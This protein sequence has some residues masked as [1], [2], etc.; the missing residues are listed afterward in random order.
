MEDLINKYIIKESDYESD[1]S[2]EYNLINNIYNKCQPFLKEWI[3]SFKNKKLKIWYSGRI[4][5]GNVFTGKIRTDRKPMNTS[6]KYH[7]PLNKYFKDT[8][9]IEYR[10]N[11]IF[12][13]GDY[14]D[15][16]DYGQGSPFLIFPI[17]NY[18]YL[19]SP[20]IDDLYMHTGVIFSKPLDS[21]KSLLSSYIHNKDMNKAILSDNEIMLNGTEYIGAR[22]SIWNDILLNWFNKFRLEKPTQKLIDDNIEYLSSIYYGKR[23]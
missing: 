15:A 5:K 20:N 3:N 1:Y 13:T 18:N 17:G 22:S 16:N 14:N 8:Y 19:W 10:S 11:S 6:N 7:I 12:V 21:K 9:G 23:I 2:A 4:G